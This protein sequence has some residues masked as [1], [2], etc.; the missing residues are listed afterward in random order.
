[1]TLPAQNFQSQL[2]PLEEL[3]VET[4]D[5]GRLYTTPSGIRYPSATT[6][7]GLHTK[8]GIDAWKKRVGEEEAAKV[9]RMAAARGTRFH[10]YAEQFLQNKQ[11]VCE[12]FFDT[13]MFSAAIPTFYRINNIIAQENCLYS[14]HLRMA[15][16][17]DLVAEFDGKRSIIDFKTASKEKDPDH[18][19][20]YFMQ[21]AAYAIMFEERT[22]IPVSRIVLI[23][24][25]EDGGVQVMTGKRDDY[26]EKLLFYRDLYE[27]LHGIPSK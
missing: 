15:G 16:R 10:S 22:R 12:T 8:R 5:Y 2:I 19:V 17:V 1:M 7:V 4:T 6:V 25:T 20:H 9:G 3:E 23:I 11:V 18:V 27:S 14:E 21:G 26:V 13:L 24:A